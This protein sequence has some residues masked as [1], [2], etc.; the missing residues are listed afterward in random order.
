[1]QSS[2]EI[3]ASIESFNIY[4]KSV[5]SK[6]TTQNEPT[7]INQTRLAGRRWKIIIKANCILAKVMCEFIYELSLALLHFSEFTLH[8]HKLKLMLFNFCYRKTKFDK[9]NSDEQSEKEKKTLQQ[10]NY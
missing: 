7:R 2:C 9:H 3:G 1:M 8:E 6:A 10:P 4:V 5:T